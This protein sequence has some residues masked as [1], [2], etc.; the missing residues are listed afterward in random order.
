MNPETNPLSSTTSYQERGTLGIS[1]PPPSPGGFWAAII[2][3][4]THDGSD[5]DFPDNRHVYEWIR[6]NWTGTCGEW[7]EDTT[8]DFGGGLQHSS[9]D[10]DNQIIYGAVEVNHDTRVPTNE[11]VWLRIGYVGDDT[12]GGFEFVFTRFTG[13]IPVVLSDPSAASYESSGAFLTYTVKDMRGV[14]L[15]IDGSCEVGKIVQGVWFAGTKG[16][17]YKLPSGNWQLHE[18]FETMDRA[19]CPDP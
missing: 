19:V 9:T 11:I 8:Q 17:A 5:P 1:G 7:E 6:I 18:A 4:G 14:T 2:R 15:I 12:P 3:N 13:L 16:T 10:G